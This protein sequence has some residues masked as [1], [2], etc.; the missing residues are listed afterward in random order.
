[1]A[2]LRLYRDFYCINS[3]VSLSADTY[4]LIN[5][6]SISAKVVI[7]GTSQTIENPVVIFESTGKYYVELNPILYSIDN[8]YEV[9]WS[10]QYIPSSPNKILITRFRLHPLV[11]GHEI[12]IRLDGNDIRLEIMDSDEIRL[13]I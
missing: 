8:I 7:S 13:E 3:N 6:E 9:R 12:D 4:T 2:N 10:V 11:V 5:P 1:M